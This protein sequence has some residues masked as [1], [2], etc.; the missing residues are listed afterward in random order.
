MRVSFLSAVWYNLFVADR[1]FVRRWVR[2]IWVRL[3][4]EEGLCEKT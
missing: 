2:V 3:I 4:V 1:R